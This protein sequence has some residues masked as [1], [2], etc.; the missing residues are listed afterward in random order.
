MTGCAKHHQGACD[1]E[2]EG[3]PAPGDRD[4][5]QRLEDQAGDQRRPGEPVEECQVV[6]G[7]VPPGSD[8]RLGPDGHEPGGQRDAGGTE[9]RCHPV[10]RWW[11]PREPA[12]ERLARQEEQRERLDPL[13]ESDRDVGR[14]RPG[15]CAGRNLRRCVAADTDVEREAAADVVAVESAHRGPVDRV[16]PRGVRC[17]RDANLV[18]A[19]D[20]ASPLMPRR[21]DG[22]RVRQRGVQRLVELE[23]D[24]PGGGA[25]MSARRRRRRAQKGVRRRCEGDGEGCNRRYDERGNAA[26][27][28]CH[29]LMMEQRIS[30]AAVV[31]AAVRLIIGPSGSGTPAP[32][33]DE[34]AKSLVARI[35]GPR[36]HRGAADRRDSVRCDCVRPA[37]GSR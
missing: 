1:P 35:M 13:D 33:S 32:G 5:G 8:G 36:H 2:R 12:D 10:E 19:V 26:E 16:N 22:R 4:Q 7:A 37:D 27:C 25:E 29:G 18:G 30:D 20:L 21:I 14:L 11:S 28:R 17:Q 9:P 23:R 6:A 31:P 3:S 34:R 15:N 24:H